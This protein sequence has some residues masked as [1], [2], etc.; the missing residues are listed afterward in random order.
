M[1]GIKTKH[2][3]LYQ[4]IYANPN[5]FNHILKCDDKS[6]ILYIEDSFDLSRFSELFWYSNIKNVNFMIVE[7]E[8]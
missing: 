6:Y 7:S 1:D 4:Y 3:S 8:N 2:K 5:E